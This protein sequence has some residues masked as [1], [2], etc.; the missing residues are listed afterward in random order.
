MLLDLYIMRINFK[1]CFHQELGS[2]KAQIHPLEMRL[3][4]D[5][6]HKCSKTLKHIMIQFLPIVVYKLLI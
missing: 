5:M 6:Y 4:P 2:E 3:R 1:Y